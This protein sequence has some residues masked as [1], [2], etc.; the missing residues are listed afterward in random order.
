MGERSK[1]YMTDLRCRPGV[2]L[3]N[4]LEKLMRTAGIGEIN[5]ERKL[6]A[7]KMHFGEPGNLA[8]LRPNWA[9]AVVDLVKSHGGK[10]FLT[11]CN[12]L[13]VG[14][15]KNALDHI[16]SA[17][18]NGF[19]PL[20][21]GCQVI[22]GDG[23]RGND[24]VEV[25]VEGAEYIQT[26]KIGKAIMEADVIISLSHFKGHEQTGFGGAIK[27]LGMGCGSRRG[28]MEQHA[29]GKPMVAPRRCVG[30]RRCATQCAHGA[31]TFGEDRKASIDWD[32][33]VGC[34]RCIAVCN[35]DAIRPG[36]DA[37]MEELGCRM[38]EYAKAVVD[39][40]PQFHISLVIDVSPY[41]DCH[42]END[43]PI[44]PDVGMFASFDPVALDQA[45]A[46]A[47]GKQ[48][49]IPGSHLDE[50]M[51]REGFCD[52][53]D[54]FINSMPDTDWRVCLDHC[55]KIGI[56]TRSYELVEVK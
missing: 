45:C 18:E 38:A 6:V 55:E 8:Y 56:G 40:R 41:C 47:C 51:H 31:I 22:I 36:N 24:D 4:K 21:T 16:E 14:G 34:G 9:R 54:H 13:Y 27:N 10:P 37:A 48:S 17:Y 49:P 35:T 43:L 53:H 50:Q 33:C 20:S 39:G 26:A 1:V 15:R 5:F 19:S 30:C 52:K 42:G 3:L 46:D 11:D 12:T 23:L 7:I 29:Q 44:V 2:S 32:K 28:K 25:P